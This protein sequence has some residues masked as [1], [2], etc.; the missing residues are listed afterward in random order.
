MGD[1]RT[2]LQPFELTGALSALP[3]DLDVAVWDAIGLPSDG[4]LERVEFYVMPYTFA[5]V[6]G[7]VIAAMPGLRV[8]QTLTA[9]VEHVMP[10][11]RPDVTLCNARGVHDASTAELAVA[12]T[13]ASL[14]G[15]PDFVRAQD[16]GR[17]VH[18]LRPSLA[19]RTVLVVGYGSVGAAVERRL[20]PFE[21]DV[22]RVAR[23]AR[24]GIAGYEALPSLLGRADVV[25]LT[26]PLTEQTRGMVDASFLAGMRD[27]A[28][29]V[30]VARGPVV[31]TDALLAELDAGRLS[32][33]LDVTDP[34]PP[35]P[36]HPLWTAPGLLISPHI[37][38]NTSAFLPR[39]TRLVRDQLERYAAGEP[40]ANVVQA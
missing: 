24:D 9:G 35:P 5:P 37:G 26:V 34:E 14:R 32:A 3:A 29:L 39:A 40:L 15:I 23:R 1:R 11:I 17:W 19:D 4:V 27:G 2:V 8:V 25:V 7:E 21:C 13:L 12:L 36:D 16:R 33:A 28:L 30:N 10:F 38:G 22:L 31:D 18:G 6:I 20:L